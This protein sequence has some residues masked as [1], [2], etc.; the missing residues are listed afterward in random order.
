MAETICLCELPTPTLTSGQLSML[1]RCMVRMCYAIIAGGVVW[2][3]W[4]TYLHASKVKSTLTGYLQRRRSTPDA[5][6]LK[7]QEILAHMRESRSD[8]TIRL[9]LVWILSSVVFSTRT[10]HQAGVWSGGADFESLMELLYTGSLIRCI[11]LAAVVGSTFWCSRASSCRIVNAVFV[12]AS[13]L[14]LWLYPDCVS[15]LDN[16]RL[17][18]SARVLAASLGR[19]ALVTSL[20][21]LYLVSLGIRRATSEAIP[22]FELF[23]AQVVLVEAGL[24]MVCEWAMLSSRCRHR[25]ARTS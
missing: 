14:Q 7:V 8:V 1:A 12:V 17:D 5:E 21:I 22:G 11:P 13:A 6:A 4:Q 19:P 18:G 24:A 2:V 23:G 25:A 10:L 9:L 3:L 20:A 15:L 16:C